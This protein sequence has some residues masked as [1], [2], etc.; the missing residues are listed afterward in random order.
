M[1]PRRR[2][3]SRRLVIASAPLLFYINAS[4]FLFSPP[5]HGSD[6]SLGAY[7]PQLLGYLRR[8][9][10][11]KLVYSLSFGSRRPPRGMVGTT[12][13]T[14]HLFGGG[15]RHLGG[16][17]GRTDQLCTGL[18]AR[19]SGHLPIGRNEMGENAAHQQRIDRKERTFLP[20]SRGGFHFGG[21]SRTGG[22]TT[23][24]HSGRFVAHA[25]R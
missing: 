3:E 25:P 6:H 19:A 10:D 20:S 1:V 9:G 2:L 5:F 12:R 23:H 11:R 17:F 21:T 4:T 22:A 8:H 14:R 18:L 15:R 13:H 16:R 7:P 24:Q